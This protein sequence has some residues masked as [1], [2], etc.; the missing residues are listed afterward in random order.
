MAIA[1]LDLFTWLFERELVTFVGLSEEL[2]FDARAA[3]VMVTYLVSL[4]LL[5]RTQD[6]R[7]QLSHLALDS[8]VRGSRHD[9]R[10]YF[11][12]LRERPACAELLS[13]LRPGA[14]A[15]WASS[16]AAEDWHERLGAR[17]RP[18]PRRLPTR[19]LAARPW[20]DCWAAADR[21]SRVSRS[22]PPASTEA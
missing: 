20:S 19:I 9:L 2:E 7:I 14:P 6:E 8:L 17:R 15:A 11:G 16:A 13:R 1:E 4:G 12:S 21:S 18:D 22:L 10:S 5:E 3:D